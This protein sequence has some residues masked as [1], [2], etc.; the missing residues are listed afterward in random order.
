MGVVLYNWLVY[1]IIQI[2]TPCFHCTPP[3]QNVDY[4][5]MRTFISTLK[6]LLLL[7]LL[8][9]LP[10]LLLLLL[11]L[12]LIIILPVVVLLLMI[13]MIQL[14]LH[15]IVVSFI[16]M[17]N[18]KSGMIFKLSCLITDEARPFSY[19]RFRKLQSRVWTNLRL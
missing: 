8:L 12:L 11:L 5:T 7:L 13:I 2:T 14:R 1:N 9:L 15:N 16:S 3:L 18:L 19:P 17:L 4:K 6:L 10:L